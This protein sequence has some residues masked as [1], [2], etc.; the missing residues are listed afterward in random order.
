VLLN[1]LRWHEPFGL[2]M[3][4]AL[5]AG[6]PVVATPNGA[7]PEIVDD[8]ETGFVRSGDDELA[9]ALGRA[10][11]LD[12]STCREVARQR[13]GRDR[14][15]AQHRQLYRRVA[16]RRPEVTSEVSPEVSAR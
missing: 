2:V 3:I 15:V 11:A 16:D 13:F 8:G 5:A 4:E 1:P 7:V 14:M 6:T 10:A 9:A 12:R